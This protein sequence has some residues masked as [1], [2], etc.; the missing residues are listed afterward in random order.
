MQFNGF[1]QVGDGLCG[2]L[3]ARERDDSQEMMGRRKTRK[4]FQG[5][6]QGFG[7]L[8]EFLFV[9]V[10]QALVIQ[11]LGIIGPACERKA[12]AKSQDQNT[13]GYGSQT[14]YV[15]NASTLFL[16]GLVM[17]TGFPTFTF[18]R[19]TAFFP[20]H[21]DQV[22]LSIPLPM[23]EGMGEGRPRWLKCIQR[24]Q[25]VV[26]TVE[27]KGRILGILRAVS[28]SGSVRIRIEQ[29]LCTG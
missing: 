20:P 11:G 1:F 5:L 23:G 2:L 9:K 21:Q 7:G 10:G 29:V 19:R 26:S 17:K 24:S 16:R 12:E 4:H 22:R 3:Q 8:L 15:H 13:D 6:L 27:S 28:P 14:S 25:V 18:R